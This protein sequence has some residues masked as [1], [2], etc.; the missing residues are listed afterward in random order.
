MS[1]TRLSVSRRIHAIILAILSCIVHAMY[2]NTLDS[3]NANENLERARAHTTM[4]LTHIPES[5]PNS[6]SQWV[7]LNC[8]R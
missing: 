8:I 3:F 2:E 7:A 4:T 5:M 6:C 1:T